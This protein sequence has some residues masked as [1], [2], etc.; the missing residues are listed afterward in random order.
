MLTHFSGPAAQRR[1]ALGLAMHTAAVGDGDGRAAVGDGEGR[2][3]E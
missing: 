2:T 1:Q 3:R